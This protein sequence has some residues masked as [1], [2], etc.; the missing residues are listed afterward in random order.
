M[1]PYA[2]TLVLVGIF[3]TIILLI[4]VLVLLK[5]FIWW[6]FGIDKRIALLEQIA[7]NTDKKEDRR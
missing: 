1:N 4:A 5:G 6:L 7:R 2:I 3:A